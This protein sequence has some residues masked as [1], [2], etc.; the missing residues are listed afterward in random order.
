MDGSDCHK[1]D[2]SMYKKKEILSIL[3]YI[4]TLTLI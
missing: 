3:S 2:F 4:I 1:L